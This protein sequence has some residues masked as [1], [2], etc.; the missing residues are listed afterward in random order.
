MTAKIWRKKKKKK[1]EFNNRI[2]IE[3]SW[4]KEGPNS[5]N[6]VRK[7]KIRNHSISYD[8]LQLV[9]KNIKSSFFLFTL[10]SGIQPP[11]LVS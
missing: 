2:G 10:K 4:R 1:T 3:F 5:A 6:F 11:D 9:A 7:K 8:K